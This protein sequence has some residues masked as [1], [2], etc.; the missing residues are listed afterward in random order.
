MKK[1]FIATAIVGLTCAHAHAGATRLP[2]EMLGAWCPVPEAE[3][4]GHGSTTYVRS[5]N[6]VADKDPNCIQVTRTGYHG[7]EDSCKF[8]RIT[9]DYVVYM[10]CWSA[11]DD[12]GPAPDKHPVSAS[13]FGIVEGKLKVWPVGCPK[14]AK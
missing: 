2:A 3:Q 6:E 8:N 13:I 5:T 12:Q 1:L 14:C 10:R 11:G 7:V 9:K 4:A